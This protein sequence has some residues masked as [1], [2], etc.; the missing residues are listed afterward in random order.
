LFEKQ[1][2]LIINTTIFLSLPEFA[3]IVLK[4]IDVGDCVH[5]CVKSLFESYIE[6]ISIPTEIRM[7]MIKTSYITIP[8]KSVIISHVCYH[9]L[10]GEPSNLIS[11]FHNFSYEIIFK[12]ICTRRIKEIK[13]GNFLDEF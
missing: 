7:A 2:D 5:I 1:Y 11:L 8:M 13:I 9:R 6:D 3:N 12:Y 4:D 10:N